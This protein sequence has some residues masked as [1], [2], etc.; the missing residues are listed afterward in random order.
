MKVPRGLS[1]KHVLAVTVLNSGLRLRNTTGM[2]LFY[3]FPK[4]CVSLALSDS[5]F[6]ESD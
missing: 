5:Y 6:S 2:A 4:E 3:F 1:G